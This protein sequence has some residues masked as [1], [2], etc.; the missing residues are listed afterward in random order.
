MWPCWRCQQHERWDL[1]DSS[2]TSSGVVTYPYL[3]NTRGQ[4]S[5]KGI[6]KHKVMQSIHT[7][8]QEQW[9]LKACS[10]LVQLPFKSLG[11]VR[12]F[13][14]TLLRSPRLHLFDQKYSKNRIIVKYYWNLKYFFS[15]NSFFNVINLCEN[16]FYS[17]FFLSKEHSKE[18][19]F[20]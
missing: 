20:F 5:S 8:L 7:L 12:F 3:K 16:F 11:S 9:T 10:V 4:R 13:E 2:T 14:R 6:E 19:N 17:G 18:Q 15:T 1:W